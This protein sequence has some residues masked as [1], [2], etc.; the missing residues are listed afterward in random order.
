MGRSLTRRTVLAAGAS[1]P[2]AQL[3]SAA[4]FDWKRFKGTPLRFMV[5]VHPWTEW[6]QKQLPALEAETGIKMNLEIL[7]EDQLR[8]KLPLTLRSDPGAVDGFFTLPSWDGA[9]FSRAHWYAPLEPLISSDLTA[10]DWDF[11]D[12]FPN[13]LNIHRLNGQLL[14][15]PI[16]TEVQALF[17][18]K[19]MLSA[20]GIAPPTTLDT[21]M[22]AAKALNDPGGNVAGF[23]TRGDGVQALY[24]FAPF[25]FAYGGRWL[26]DQGKPELAGAPFINALKYY[27]DILRSAGP[28]NILG[29][30]WKTSYP[31]F[32]QE[33]A[34]MFADAVNF[35]AYF[36][37]PSQSKIVDKVA[38][39]PVP[40]GPAG[41]HST[42]IAWGP[43]IAASSK[44]QQA[45]WY[46][47]QWLTSKRNMLAA[48]LATTLPSSRKSVYTADDYVK[49]APAGVIDIVQ[50][51]VPNAVPNGANPLVVQVPETRAAIGQAIVAALRGED[52][53]KAA[54]EAQKQVLAIING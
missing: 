34:A 31:L 9:A 18:N 2:I 30:Q 44:K 38:M 46:A 1:V 35:L 25:L 20:K 32:Q 23:V 15:I 12:F 22:V 37:D 51:Q 19:A 47:I 10:P 41:S 6:A 40:A 50:S 45:T 48:S 24:T 29:M 28:P 43:A 17:Y 7:Y 33:R 8:Q 26:D 53:T 54:N 39:V 21:L 27:S 5:S 36:R 3:A 49:A 13:I 11:A 16:S 4:D 42:V 14:G 52:V